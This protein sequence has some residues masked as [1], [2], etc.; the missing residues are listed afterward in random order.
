MILLD[1]GSTVIMSNRDLKYFNPS[2]WY[3]NDE[4]PT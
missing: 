2:M 3:L 1:D 4:L